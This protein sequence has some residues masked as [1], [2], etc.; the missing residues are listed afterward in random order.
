MIPRNS[1]C[2]DPAIQDKDIAHWI[3]W[4]E[5]HFEKRRT[6]LHV[7]IRSCWEGAIPFKQLQYTFRTRHKPKI[8]EG[9]IVI[10]HQ[11]LLFF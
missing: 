9:A 10:F 7:C 11:L 6:R 2:L 4:L 8:E 1:T 5:K 3:K